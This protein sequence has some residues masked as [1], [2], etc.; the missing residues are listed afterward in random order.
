MTVYVDRDDKGA[1]AGVYARPQRGGQETLLADD[2]E[3]VAF[4]QR[5][6]DPPANDKI[7]AR[8][9]ND[10]VISGLVGTLAKHLGL[11]KEEIVA[12]MKA[13]KANA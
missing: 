3:V 11:T 10:P 9:A 13:E 4:V 7:D 8:V 2:A 6:I 1:I 5:V 12:D